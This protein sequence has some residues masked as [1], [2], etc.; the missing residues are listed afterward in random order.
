MVRR[1]WHF[2]I[3][4]FDPIMHDTERPMQEH[5]VA[6]AADILMAESASSRSDSTNVCAMRSNE[7]EGDVNANGDGETSVCG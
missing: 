7:L 4:K 6:I 5:G 2:D 3:V 1:S